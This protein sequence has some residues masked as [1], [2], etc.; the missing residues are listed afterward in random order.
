MGSSNN[1]RYPKACQETLASMLKHG[2]TVHRSS[3]CGGDRTVDLEGMLAEEGPR[4]TLWNR[5][6]LCPHCRRPGHYLASG[7]PVMLPLLSDDDWQAERFALQKSLGLSPR[8][9]RRIKNFAV[10]VTSYLPDAKGLADLDVAI[11]ITARRMIIDPVPEPYR[12]FGQWEGRD[13]LFRDFNAGERAVWE[14]RPK[15]PRSL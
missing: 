13:L 2:T 1:R 9:R 12:A 11:F 4:A 14:R 15:G 8:D 5:R 7:A 3:C 10:K 6:P